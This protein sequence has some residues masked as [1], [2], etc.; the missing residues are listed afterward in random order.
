MD[1]SR[2]NFK[3][4]KT[5]Q[6]CTSTYKV[7]GLWLFNLN[8]ITSTFV[9]SVVCSILNR[10]GVLTQYLDWSG[11]RVVQ[12]FHSLH[13]SECD[14]I[15]IFKGDS[16]VLKHCYYSRIF[17]LKLKLRRF[18]SCITDGELLSKIT[19]YVGKHSSRVCRD[20]CNS[21]LVAEGIDS[22]LLV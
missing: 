7:Y 17:L 4:L 6:D 1:S 9:C 12:L 22:K 16:V 18:S 13:F 20:K 19:K 11:W 14:V 15:S 5:I 2:D 21:L 10:E 3:G 8:C